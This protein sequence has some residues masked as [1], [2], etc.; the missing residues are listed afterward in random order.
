MIVA[1]FS[2]WAFAF[3]VSPIR[4]GMLL[5][6]ASWTKFA[7]LVV[8]PLWSRYPRSGAEP[9]GRSFLQG[10]GGL[11][12]GTAL[13]GLLLLPGGAGLHAVRLFWDRTAGFQL[14]RS[15]PFSIWDWNGYLPGFPSLGGVQ[16]ALEALLVTAAVLL[17]FRPRRLDALQ[18]AAFSGA[19][20]LGFEL[21]LTHWSYLYLP[22]AFPFALLALVLPSQRA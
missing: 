19:L 7:P 16:T 8:W 4:R 15:S 14:G 22:W 6:L 9:G 1:A 13:A 18:L 3:A 5:A 2:I 21:V 17:A 20:V 12:A 11:A 10:V